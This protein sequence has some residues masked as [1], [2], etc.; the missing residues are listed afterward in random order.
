MESDAMQ[1]L[2]EQSMG[3]HTDCW[4]SR[5]AFV[6]KQKFSSDI[7]IVLLKTGDGI[8][9]VELSVKLRDSA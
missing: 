7:K 9:T 1:A 8:K 5:L 3:A 6:S 2:V 4:R